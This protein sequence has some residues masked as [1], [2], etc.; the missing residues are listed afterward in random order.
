MRKTV[1]DA[2]R[3][4]P[5]TRKRPRRGEGG[6]PCGRLNPEAW[7]GRELR[8]E[9][10]LRVGTQADMFPSPPGQRGRGM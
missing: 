10:S 1:I 4:A 3:S 7:D 8:D 5:E 2:D 6:G 9:W